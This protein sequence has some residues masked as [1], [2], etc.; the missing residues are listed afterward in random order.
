MNPATKALLA[1][2]EIV[3]QNH[4]ATHPAL[5]EETAQDIAELIA[6]SK[7]M[8]NP[9]LPDAEPPEGAPVE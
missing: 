4:L 6:R 5:K 3:M 1:L 9:V 8:T 7:S 2:F